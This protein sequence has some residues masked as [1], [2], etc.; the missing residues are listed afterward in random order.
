V[1]LLQIPP[2][3]ILPDELHHI[4]QM[5]TP[6][7]SPDPVDD[8]Y[9]LILKLFAGRVAGYRKC[10][11]G[12]HDLHHTL[13]VFLAMARLLQGALSSGCPL[14]ERAVQ[15]GLVAALFH[16]TGYLQ[17]DEDRDGTGA[18]HTVVHEQRSIDLL[19]KMRKRLGLSDREAVDC[20]HII[21]CTN[22]SLDVQDL[23]FRNGTVA[24]LGKIL[25]TSDIVGQMADRYYLEKL[26]HL[27]E[28][29]READVL[30]GEEEMDLLRRTPAFFD[31][32][33]Q[34][35]S[36]T[37]GGMYRMLDVH[38]FERWGVRENLY[39]MAIRRHRKHLE[40]LL[41]DEGAVVE[42]YLRRRT[43]AADEWERWRRPNGSVQP[44][45]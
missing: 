30:M 44:E 8:A 45:G 38:C 13:S 3:D 6:P 2:P 17:T 27:Y 18:K 10:N 25:G 41:A 40:R 14:D 4:L 15:L 24:T 12:Y 11:T 19:M 37:M 31:M 7:V 16:D 26:H 33:E 34:R 1:D 9:Q 32:I 43:K 42:R 20:S 21:Q 22:L 36:T 23:P 29:F 35:L 5:M 39:R 28:E